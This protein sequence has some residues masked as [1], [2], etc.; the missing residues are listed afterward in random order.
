MTGNRWSSP[1]PISVGVLF[2]AAIIDRIPLELWR[3]PGWL[4]YSRAAPEQAMLAW[5]LGQIPLCV[6]AVVV[7]L[8]I[9]PRSALRALGLA[10]SR[11]DWVVA[12]AVGL[13]CSLP[14]FA[15]ALWAR[16]GLNSQ[17]TIWGALRTSIGSGLGEEVLFRG[18]LFLVLYRHARWPFWAAALASA[19][20]WVL[21]HLY[22]TPQTGLD[23]VRGTLM[24][25]LTFTVFGAFAAW[26]LVS[27][28]D[29][30][31]VLVAIHGFANLSWYLFAENTVPLFGAAGW[32]MRGGVLIIAILLTIFRHRIPLGPMGRRWPEVAA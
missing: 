15:V 3:I 7:I 20:P 23:L 12:F 19:I 4:T 28:N 14:I 32:I 5:K 17:A 6:L 1:S 24:I 8:H 26:V 10:R 25:A 30:L 21:G 31:W 27:W 16:T 18:L 11:R 13:A 9:S 2:C 29:N 22:Q